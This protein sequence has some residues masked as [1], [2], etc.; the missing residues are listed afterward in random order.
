MIECEKWRGP[1][2]E[3]KKKKKEEGTAECGFELGTS[4][5]ITWPG[6]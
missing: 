6:L 5:I 4:P 3:K 1:K 2:E